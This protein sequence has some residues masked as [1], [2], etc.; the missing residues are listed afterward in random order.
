MHP[1]KVAVT[2][3]QPDLVNLVEFVS[4]EPGTMPLKGRLRTWS[5]LMG[6]LQTCASHRGRTTNLS[7]PVSYETEGVYVVSKV[8]VG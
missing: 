5:G 7:L 2:D 8:N 6:H 4:G 1:P 3:K